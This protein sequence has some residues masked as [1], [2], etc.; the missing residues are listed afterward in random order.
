MRRTREVKLTPKELE[1]LSAWAREERAPDPYVLPAHR[2]Q[3]T[4]Q[5]RGVFLI[6]AIKA[7]ARSSGR[8]DEDI[9]DLSDN[10]NPAWPWASAEEANTR[11]A[12]GTEVPA[13]SAS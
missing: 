5:V 11:L 4:H 10:A 9:F 12:A 8:K 1:F 3:A 13:R 7:W 6:R 2:L